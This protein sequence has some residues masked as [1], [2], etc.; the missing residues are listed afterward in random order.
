MFDA[1]Q[2]SE[3]PTTALVI[4]AGMGGLAA[5]LRLQASGHQVTLFDT[6]PWPG[7]KMRTV[8]SEAGPVDAGPTVLTMRHVFDDLFAATGARLEDHV[9]LIEE[10]LLARHFWPDG[11]TL[12]LTNNHDTNAEAITH[13]ASETV[14]QEYVRFSDEA[15]SLFDQ[16]STTMMLHSD[17]QL[18]QLAKAA[19]A[20]PRQLGV[21]SPLA[22]L[23]KHLNRRFSD[24]R[25]VQLF[26][27]YATYVGGSPLASP[28]ILS[29]IWQAE[30]AGVWRVKGGMHRLALALADRFEA[31]GGTLRLGTP[32][33]AITTDNGRATGVTLQT[34]ETQTADLVIFAG[35]PRALATGKLGAAVEGVASVTRTQQRSFSARVWSFAAH[36][37]TPRDLAYHNIFFG[38]S[39]TE[40]F[41]AIEQGTMPTDPTI[42]ICAEDRGHET[43]ASKGPERF[44][45]ILN[46]A[47]L[48]EARPPIDEEDTC[49]QT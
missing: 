12:D 43:T 22:T 18:P 11:S 47:P 37:N 2:L 5:A 23:R 8:P 3:R 30:A 19:L 28:A 39:P 42:Y 16:F 31:I 41:E 49:R 48:T 15:A 36:A 44:E 25:L 35:D 24:P 38:T 26:G 4:G 40:E 45:I 21:L 46:A 14:A 33:A 6:H 1:N 10:H 13:F 34:G 29:L 20:K 27:R 32:I 7:G 17:P 9:T